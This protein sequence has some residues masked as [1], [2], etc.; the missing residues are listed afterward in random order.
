MTNLEAAIKDLKKDK[1]R[2]PNGWLNELFMNEVAGANLKLSMLKLFNRMKM[3]N[4]YPDFMR[5]ADVTTIYKG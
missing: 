1:A 2:D 3:E 4:Y 5:K